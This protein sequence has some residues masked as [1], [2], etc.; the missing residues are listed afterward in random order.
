MLH[1]QEGDTS[2]GPCVSTRH[3]IAQQPLGVE[4]RE[5]KPREKDMA[6]PAAA[7]LVAAAEE[8][9]HHKPFS[10]LPPPQH[11]GSGAHAQ[12]AGRGGAGRAGPG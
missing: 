6:L 5:G 11:Q 10:P 7:F 1:N 8:T 12:S 4:V 9:K 2:P 3:G